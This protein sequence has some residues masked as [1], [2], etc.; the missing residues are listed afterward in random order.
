MATS[1]PTA[2]P[3]R[4]PS[5][6]RR[7]P[8]GAPIPQSWDNAFLT[9]PIIEPV[10]NAKGQQTGLGTAI[11]FFNQDPKVSKQ[12]RY[13]IGF[14]RELPYNIIVEGLYLGNYGY[15]IEITRNINALPTQYLS[16]S[17][18]RDAAMTA[19]NAF[20]TAS[21]ANPFAGLLPGTSFNNATIARTQLLRPYPAFGD[22]T[23]TNNDG[24][25][26][27]NSGQFGL[28]KRFSKGNTLGISY[29]YSRWEQAD[30]VPERRRR[31]SDADDLGPRRASPPRGQ[32]HL[33]APLRQG[34]PFRG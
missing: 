2:I 34:A 18:S 24:K 3:R 8:S 14:Q 13:Q 26:W 11:T 6:R 9:T 15:D 1:S 23:T 16:T 7:S 10:G 19:N 12:F 28:Q 27:Y 17:N 25:S 30:G 31:Q 20:L 22:I 4:P 32:R 21:V 5:E 33:P 29:T